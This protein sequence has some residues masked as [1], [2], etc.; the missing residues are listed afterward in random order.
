M[1]GHR[2]SQAQ[3]AVRGMR[4]QGRDYDRA[5]L[6]RNAR[7]RVGV[8]GRQNQIRVDSV[9][10]GADGSSRL[11]LGDTSAPSWPQAKRN[12]K[13]NFLVGSEMRLSVELVPRSAAELA[14]DA[15]IVKT[16]LPAANALNLPDLTRFQLR[17]WEACQVTSRIVPAS[18]P[19]L[20][21][22]DF[23][24]GQAEEVAERLL[25][26][27]LREVLVVRG[28][29]PHDLSRRTYPNSSEDVIR[30]LKRNFPELV[31]YAAYD[32][33]R[34]GFRE[35][36][37]AVKRKA[38]AGADGFFTQPIFDLNL[39][40]VC[41]DILHGFNVFWGIAPVLGEKSRAYWEVTNKVVFPQE[42]EP[43]LAWNT[44]FARRAMDFVREAGGNAYLMPIRIDLRKYLA[45]LT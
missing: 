28:D 8:S 11:F 42:F 32:P 2:A 23:G 6:E 38:D 45:E 41:A 21:A 25:Q 5:E 44:A 30:R 33:Y 14:S 36:L 29:P 31:V 12:W 1:I 4:W 20:R 26:A 43:T 22:I 19:H 3:R 34:A 17:S 10:I 9:E 35:E 16:M 39:L 40:R 27:G 7:W 24:P 37:E 18:I 13:A 15:L